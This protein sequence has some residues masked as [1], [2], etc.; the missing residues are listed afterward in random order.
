MNCL[1]GAFRARRERAEFSLEP[2]GWIQVQV[3]LRVA[4]HR[5]R[6]VRVGTSSHV[7]FCADFPRVE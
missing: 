3:V 4:E 7:P 1:A 6:G 2:L 5:L